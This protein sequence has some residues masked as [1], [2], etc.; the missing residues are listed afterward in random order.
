MDKYTKGPLI[1]RGDIC[2]IYA[3]SYRVEES[4]SGWKA[5][6]QEVVLKQARSAADND[7]L[8]VEEKILKHLHNSL[9]GDSWGQ[10]VSSVY[11]SRLWETENPGRV[12][13]NCLE[14]FPGFFTVEQI[15]EMGGVDCRTMVW[16]W[17]RLLGLLSWVHSL[18][19]Q[20]HGAI[21]PPHVMYYP[22]NNM[23]GGRDPRKH[24][25]RLVDW[26]YSTPVGP[27]KLKAWLPRWSSFYPSTV[28]RRL[29]VKES[30]DINMAA[31]T[32]KYVLREDEKIP[33]NIDKAFKLSEGDQDADGMLNYLSQCIVLEYGTPSFHRFILP[34]I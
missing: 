16:M 11:A 23:R 4:K 18:T 29:V 22:D 5:F 31:A 17:K 20:V 1:A 3:G 14:A 7:L 6:S 12:I 25:V 13:T 19:G 9:P 34:S 24:S 10:C 27:G 33:M 26:C 21:L 15:K 2:D 8:L 30:I 28:K 32:M